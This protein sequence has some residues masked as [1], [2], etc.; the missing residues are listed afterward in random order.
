ME[1]HEF[2]NFLSERI[3]KKYTDLDVTEIINI[4]ETTIDDV[5]AIHNT[6]IEAKPRIDEN[7]KSFD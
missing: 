1:M 6:I 4:I 3:I 2:I 7:Y 5:E